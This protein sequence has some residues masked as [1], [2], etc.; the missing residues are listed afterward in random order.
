MV[1][2]PDQPAVA[3]AAEQGEM[4]RRLCGDRISLMIVGR[5]TSRSRDIE[6]A[7]GLRVSAAVPRD[8]VAA[9]VASGDS[10]RA[11][12][13]ARSVLVKS[14]RRIADSFASLDEGES[15]RLGE[16][17]R[18]EKEIGTTGQSSIRTRAVSS[19]STGNAETGPRLDE[20]EASTT[21]KVLP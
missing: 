2:G 11:R 19:D 20:P 14:A 12:R 5:G 7:T 16:R 3:H 9:A 6:A 18:P 4:L 15:D 10:S 21:L 13:L 8:P 17:P 1:I